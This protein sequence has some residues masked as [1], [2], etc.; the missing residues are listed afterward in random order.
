MESRR[1]KL[2]PMDDST[3]TISGTPTQQKAAKIAPSTPAA[4]ANGAAPPC[5][6]R[7][8]GSVNGRATGGAEARVTAGTRR[9]SRSRELVRVA[10]ATPRRR[11]RR[12]AGRVARRGTGTSGARRSRRPFAGCSSA[13]ASPGD[14]RAE[15]RAVQPPRELERDTERVHERARVPRH[16]AFT[17]VARPE[18]E[19][20]VA[21]RRH[22]VGR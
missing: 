4:S 12:R 11:C 19:D 2:S 13:S 9:P 15:A 22:R 5:T 14:D 6:R 7:G 8:A 3:L 17:R 16:P 21:E 20:E 18:E 1:R 10:R